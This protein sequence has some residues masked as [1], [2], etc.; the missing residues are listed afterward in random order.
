MILLGIRTD[1][2]HKEPPLTEMTQEGIF[3]DRNC[4]FYLLGLG[5]G[6][7]ESMLQV[8]VLAQD[9]VYKEPIRQ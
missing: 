2:S 5:R 9:I 3:P 7:C 6:I 8:N 1:S 4:A